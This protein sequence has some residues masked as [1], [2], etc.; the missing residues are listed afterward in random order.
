M[1]LNP[2]N[3]FE[4]L[5]FYYKFIRGKYPPEQAQRIENETNTA[6]FRYLLLGFRFQRLD[7]QRKMTQEE[8]EAAKAYM[9]QLS[10]Q[11]LP[12][13]RVALQQVF[14]NLQVSQAIRNVSGG[15]VNQ[16]MTWAEQE[17]WYPN[18]RRRSQRVADQCA[19]P[20]CYKYGSVDATPLMPGK[21]RPLKYGVP[22]DRISPELAQTLEQ[23]FDFLS[24]PSYASRVIDAVG[25]AT[26]RG[27]L[28]E[29]RLFLGWFHFHHSPPIPLE[30]L[31]L[32]L[33]FPRVPEDVLEGMT[34]KERKLFWRQ[35][36]T[37]LKQWVKD[38]FQF[39]SEKLHSYSPRTRTGKL[40]AIRAVA[41]FQYASEVEDA[42]EYSQIPLFVALRDLQ[43]EYEEQAKDWTINRQYVAD[44]SKKWPE[45]PEGKTAL[46]VVQET[47]MEPLRQCCRPRDSYGNF[48]GPKQL[49]SFLEDAL[50]WFNL[51]IEP[52]RR[53][54][55]A[56]T[57]KVGLVCPVERPQEV[58]A[59]GFYHPLLPPEVRDQRSD[60]TLGDNYLYR[61][62]N[63]E[64]KVYPQGVWVRQIC[65]Y[66]TRKFHGK[67]TIIIPNRLFE[68]GTWLYDYIE[69][70]LYG[71]W[72]PGSFRDSQTYSWWD[73]ELK[74]QRGRWITKGRMEFEPMDCCCLPPNQKTDLWSWGY[75]FPVPDLGIPYRDTTFSYAFAQPAHERIGK[76]ITPHTMRYI[77]ATWAFQVGLSDAQLR[78]LAAAMGCTVQTLR[79][80]YERSTPEEKR[81]PIEE[82]IQQLL[83][84]EE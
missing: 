71:W 84:E 26:A 28:K 67:Q 1:T 63:L 29:T 64:G 60:G 61:T 43:K 30:Q 33:I 59:A 18:R 46:K 14:D 12:K 2:K 47:V 39:L 9:R 73:V 6:V 24:L 21:S 72:L 48:H 25:E 69:W 76:R 27:Y 68:D 66:K 77:W 5:E 49:A 36:K 8:I 82:A 83:F 65:A 56:R 31:S 53:Q 15:R 41:Y 80:M 81:R 32:D 55:E 74:G 35:Q 45:V 51:A 79:T 58:P 78:S 38:Y 10:L 19:P 57:C 3:W 52:A 11:C 16:W 22:L 23:L 4:V 50:M 37:V 7:V 42:G 17:S 20:R 13:V 40:N 54:Q 44:Q 75:L 70:Y 34:P 62:Y